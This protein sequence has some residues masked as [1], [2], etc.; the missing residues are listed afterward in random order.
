MRHDAPFLV[1]RL[2]PMMGRRDGPRRVTVAFNAYTIQSALVA[3]GEDQARAA[4]FPHWRESF[5]IE[6]RDQPATRKAGKKR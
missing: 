1:K 4:R 3:A 5:W 6:R 2:A